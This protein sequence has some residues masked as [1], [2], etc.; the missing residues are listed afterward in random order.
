MVARAINAAF[1]QKDYFYTDPAFTGSSIVRDYTGTL[2]QD[3]FIYD[4]TFD[5]AMKSLYD[6]LK[7][8][9]INTK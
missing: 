1:S 9:D 6:E 5:E 3:M 4:R 8:L 7:S 2:V